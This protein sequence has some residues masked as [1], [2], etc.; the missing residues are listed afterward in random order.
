MVLFGVVI[1]LFATV[2]LHPAGASPDRI[3]IIDL[4]IGGDGAPELRAELA[5]SIARGITDTNATP[6]PLDTVLEIL[7]T[8]PR[9]IGCISTTCLARIGEKLDVHG[10]IRAKIGSEGA[11]YSIELELFDKSKLLH[12]IGVACSPCTLGELN[13]RLRKATTQLI[14]AVIDAP[15][16]VL[17]R[18]KPSGSELAID[19]EPVGP[20]PYKGVLAIGPHLIVATNPAGNST[21]LRVEVTTETAATPIVINMGNTTEVGT[22]WPVPNQRWKTWKWASAG[23]AVLSLSG[24]LYLFSIDGEGTCN[25]SDAECPMVKETTLGAVGLTALTLSLAGA[26]AWMFWQDGKTG[27]SISAQAAINVSNVSL[28]VALRF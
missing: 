20:A 3:A 10:F 27:A 25:V 23:A 16:S 26:S 5:K 9:L 14:S 21:R 15:I 1:G 17:I 24:A 8:T 11:D 12:R 22:D 28:S 4:N 13:T 2:G 19:G 18:T 7:K 6:V